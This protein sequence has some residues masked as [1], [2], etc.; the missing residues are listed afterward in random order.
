MPV[1]RAQ[2]GRVSGLP[3]QARS[4]WYRWPDMNLWPGWE[5]SLGVGRRA[6]SCL[7]GRPV[8]FPRRWRWWWW[9]VTTPA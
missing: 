2:A 4:P 5:S 9:R 7:S 8:T 6:E 3:D 1:L